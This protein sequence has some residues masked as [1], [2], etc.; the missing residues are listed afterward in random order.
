MTALTRYRHCPVQE[1]TLRLIAF[2]LRHN[3]FCLPLTM[4]R[5][6]I[7]T[8]TDGPTGGLGL[9]QLHHENVP[10][11]DV[12]N[13]VY[14]AVPLLPGQHNPAPGPPAL[15]QTESPGQPLQS[16]LVVDSAQFGLLG[17]R[18]DGVPSLK[19]AR[20]SAFSPIPP[21]YLIVNRLQGIN[22]LVIPDQAE[23]P[24]FLLEVD[25]LVF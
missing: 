18:I 23:P 1:P 14:Q 10:V 3:W 7:P 5:R 17:L 4:A 11:I 25:T 21:A 19:R 12:A 13:R 24:L 20:K 15:G 9:A 2:Q 8:V 16:I 22:T 6:V